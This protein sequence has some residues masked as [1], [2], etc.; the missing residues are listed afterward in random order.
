MEDFFEQMGKLGKNIPKNQESTLK[1]LRAH[2]GMEIMGPPLQF[3]L[4]EF[5]I[6]DNARAALSLLSSLIRIK[7]D[8]N[9]KIVHSK[10]TKLC[11]RSS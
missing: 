4:V 8:I 9:H 6:F 11:L 10:K 7:P 3:Q 1:Q 5:K 2:H